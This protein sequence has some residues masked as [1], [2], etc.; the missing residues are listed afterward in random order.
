MQI[1]LS[2][3]DVDTIIRDADGAAL[4]L[5]YAERAAAARRAAGKDTGTIRLE[6]DGVTI[7][8]DL[9]KRVDWD[10]DRLGELV[11]RIRSAGADP[12]DYVEITYKIPERRYAAWPPSIREDFAPARTVE[13]GSL[14]IKLQEA[15]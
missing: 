14:N 11:E 12:A 7:L 5:R 6:D 10:Q 4:S 2:P 1:E 15:H 13:T 3:D 9:P 8:A